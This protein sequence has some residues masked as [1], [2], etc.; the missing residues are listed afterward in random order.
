MTIN[1]LLGWRRLVATF[2]TTYA[3]MKV[4]AGIRPR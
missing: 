3:S 1:P 2:S 4:T